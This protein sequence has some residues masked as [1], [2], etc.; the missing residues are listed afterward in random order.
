MSL[1]SL[2]PDHPLRRMAQEIADLANT[3]CSRSDGYEEAVVRKAIAALASVET[4]MRMTARPYMDHALSCP[5]WC[6]PT[7]AHEL[8][9]CGLVRLLE[10]ST[11]FDVPAPLPPPPVPRDYR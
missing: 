1:F 4:H 8:C 2:V 3:C 6:A 10:R 9:R 11:W 5:S 7:L